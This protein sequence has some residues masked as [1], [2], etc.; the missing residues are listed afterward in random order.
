MLEPTPISS[1]VKWKE[2]DAEFSARWCSKTGAPPPRR[3]LVV[4]DRIRADTAYRLICTGNAL[5]WHGDYYNAC[6][7][8]SAL[9]RRIDR[10]SFKTAAIP[11][12]VF[13]AY[14]LFRSQ[15]AHLLGLLL[16][17]LEASYRIPLHRAPDVVQTCME[18]YGQCQGPSVVSLRELLGIIGAREWR[19]K[20]ILIPSLDER[21]HPHYGVFSPV[22]GEYVDMVAQAPLPHGTGEAFDIG[23]GTGVLAAILAKRGVQKIV[24][25][26]ISSMAIA[27]ARDN[28]SRLGYREHVEIVEANLFPEG[29]AKLIVCNPPWIPARPTVPFEIAIYDQDSRMLKGFLSGLTSHLVPGGEG[30]LILSDIAENLGLRTRKELL[31]WIAAANLRIVGRLDIKPRHPK[32][33]DYNDPLNFARSREVTS[34]W[35][36]MEAPYI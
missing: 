22:R 2:G 20:G 10:H 33:N 26:D 30:W 17:P 16:L 5:L 1:L 25:T 15:R 4:D 36:L 7:L 32:I 31:S 12:D 14:R 29:R 34:L 8:L 11:R 3:I 23:T 35:R 9:S 6:Q 28:I 27:C 21:I 13:N 18:V 19:S 24:A